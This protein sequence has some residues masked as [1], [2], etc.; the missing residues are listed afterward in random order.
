MEWLLYVRSW[1]VTEI[2]THTN[3]KYLKKLTSMNLSVRPWKLKLCYKTMILLKGFYF[4]IEMCFSLIIWPPTCFEFSW[5]YFSQMLHSHY[6]YLGIHDIV[7]CDDGPGIKAQINNQQPSI[8]WRENSFIQHLSSTCYMPC[9][10]LSPGDIKMKKKKN[11]SLRPRVSKEIE[12]QE[13]KI[14]Q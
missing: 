1:L 8:K 4:S 3:G 5:Y 12:E 9:T 7:L 13:R 14:T 2:K 11:Q 10:V 6:F